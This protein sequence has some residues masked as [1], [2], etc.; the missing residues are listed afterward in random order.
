MP[1]QSRGS[2]DY[3][4]RH[5]RFG[6]WSLFVFITF[7]LIL[8]TL[9]AFKVRAYLDVSNDTRRLMWTLAHAHGT[10]LSILH[11]IFGLSVRAILPPNLRSQRLI[12]SCLNRSQYPASGRILPWGNLVLQRRPWARGRGGTAWRQSAHDRRLSARPPEAARRKNLFPDR[13]SEVHVAR[14]IGSRCAAHETDRRRSAASFH[15]DVTRRGGRTGRL[16]SYRGPQARLP[17]WPSRAAKS[18]FRAMDGREKS[19]KC[20]E[21]CL[22][23]RP[24]RDNYRTAAPLGHTGASPHQRYL[25]S[26]LALR[27]RG[28]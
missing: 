3:A 1:D 18:G 16:R 14:E 9:H 19:E 24:D 22:I 17:R 13:R 20:F 7:G 8:E 15:P 6:W 12:S 26:T 4:L 5:L 23:D 27:G 21:K 25:A 11:V 2:P 10:L 28:I